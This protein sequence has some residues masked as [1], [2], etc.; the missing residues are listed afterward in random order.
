M[1]TIAVIGGSGDL[2]TAEYYKAINKAV[3]DRLGGKHSAEVIINS[4]DFAKSIHHVYGDLW[5]EDAVYIHA[6]AASL[7]RAGAALAWYVPGK[8]E[9]RGFVN[10]HYLGAGDGLTPPAPRLCADRRNK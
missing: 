10:G 9:G 6:K 7:E 3:N 8:R 1:L 2:A 5:D 4:M